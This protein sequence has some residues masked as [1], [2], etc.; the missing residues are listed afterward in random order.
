MEVLTACSLIQSSCRGEKDLY[1]SI[2]SNEVARED[3]SCYREVA[4][5]RR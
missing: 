3:V 1:S 4:A 5:E 2:E